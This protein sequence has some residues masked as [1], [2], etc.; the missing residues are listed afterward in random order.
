[1]TPIRQAFIALVQE[2]KIVP[3]MDK[4]QGRV[5][6]LAKEHAAEY[7]ARHQVEP[8]PTDIAVRLLRMGK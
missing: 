7:A 4:K 6:C 5:R 1:M 3:C 2:G 8:L